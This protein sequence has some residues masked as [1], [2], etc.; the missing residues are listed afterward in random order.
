MIDSA[1]RRKIRVIVIGCGTQTQKDH[2][3]AIFR[4]DELE[5][6]ALVDTDK[7]I[8][9][10]LSSE[11]N[12]DAYTSAEKAIDKTRPDV[13]LVSVPHN[14]YLPILNMLAKKS[15]AT[16]KEK[17]LAMNFSEAQEIIDL[18]AK[19]KTYLQICVQRRFSDLYET[20][21]NLILK[22]GKMYSIYIEYTLSLSAKEMASGWRS[23]RRFSGGGATLDMGYHVI[24]LLT[25]LFG[26][27]DRIY[28]QINYNSIGEGYTI[29]DTMKAMMTYRRE[30]NTNIVVTKIYNQKNEKV[31][32][33]GSDGSVYVDGRKVT[34]FD[35]D[36]NEIESHT[37]SSKQSEV[38]R[39]LDYFINNHSNSTL[40]ASGH[41][42]ILTDQLK[43]MLIID[44]IYQSDNEKKVIKL[45]EGDNE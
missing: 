8:L 45:N 30:I 3:P 19:N 11:L 4:R 41:N 44:S 20:T 42:K 27:P 15:V 6:V 10:A 5:I 33:F 29:D 2:I 43:N 21:R 35:K 17:P 39:Q 22:I 26:T 34:L 37:F 23:D 36:K 38:D 16:L 24:D 9:K 40:L 32:I 12:I 18:Y 13:A 7:S 1:K 31:R 28:G 14:A 25:Y